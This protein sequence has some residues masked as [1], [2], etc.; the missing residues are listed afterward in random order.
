MPPG[1]IS[2]SGKLGPW[3]TEQ[4]DETPISGSYSFRHAD[5]SAIAAV[6]GLLSSA[7]KF[8]GV[9]RQLHVWGATDTPQ[10]KVLR[11]GH[12]FALKTQFDAHVNATNGDVNLRRLD[13]KL[14]HTVLRGLGNILPNEQHRRTTTLDFATQDGRIEDILYLFVKGSRSPLRGITRCRG[15]VILPG[16]KSHSCTKWLSKRI[17]VLRRL[18]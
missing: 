13:A 5:L 1:E 16:G 8:D 9:I 10:F 14:G 12:R 17:L 6:G 4:R 15:Y 7:R 18:G 3:K 11:T 2:T